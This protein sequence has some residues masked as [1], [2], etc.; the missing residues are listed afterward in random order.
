MGRPPPNGCRGTACR[1][2]RSQTREAISL[3]ALTC[4]SLINSP[5]ARRISST[6][7]SP[8]PRP[9]STPQEPWHNNLLYHSTCLCCQNVRFHTERYLKK[10]IYILSAYILLVKVAFKS[11]RDNKHIFLKK[12]KS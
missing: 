3:S 9:H 1:C 12:K 5:R 7:C 8:R 10:I 11:L 6:T 4:S 2:P